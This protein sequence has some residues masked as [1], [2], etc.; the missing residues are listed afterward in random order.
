MCRKIRKIKQDTIKLL[1]NMFVH[2]KR[3]Q[4][5]WRMTQLYTSD[6]ILCVFEAVLKEETI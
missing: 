2:F 6:Y 5:G 1:K 4:T 3:I